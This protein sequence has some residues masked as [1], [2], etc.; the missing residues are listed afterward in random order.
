MPTLRALA[1]TLLTLVPA[2]RASA[3]ELGGSPSSMEN[4]HEAAVEADY[5]FLR[6]PDDVAHL[7][8]LGRLVE[9][10]G[11]VDYMLAGVSFPFTRPEVLSFI[12]HFAR[13]YRAVAHEKLV[14]TSLTRPKSMQPAN[15]HDLSVHP[16]GMAVDLRVP[17][18]AEVRRWF[19]KRLLELED[20]RAIDVTREKRPPHYHIAVFSE[21]W[22]PIADRQDS[23]WAAERARAVADSAARAAIEAAR[24]PVPGD[25]RSPAPLLFAALTALGFSVPVVR[26]ARRR[27]DRE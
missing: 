2:V 12:E 17:A 16:A 25:S 15:A 1:L 24:A 5:S 11:G 22:S 23:V 14:V 27:S 21:K 26:R 8:E 18:D 3:G 20:A 19:E 13:E 4:Q 7:V 6:R 10:S 9:V